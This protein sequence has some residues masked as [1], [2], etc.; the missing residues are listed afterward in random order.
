MIKIAV[1]GPESTGKS[2]I[3]A[4]LA[5][6]FNTVWVPEYARSYVAT[7]D[8][9][10]TLDDI[11]AIARGQ[12]ALEQEMQLQANDILFSDTD[13]L[14]LKIWSEHAFGHCPDWIQRQL[15]QQDY[16]L[17]LLMGVDLPWEPDPQREH[18]HLRQ[19]FY[20]WYKRELEA[21][22]APFVEI[23]GQEQ[24]RLELATKH[25]EALLTQR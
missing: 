20:H 13:M 14:V 16:N 3:A 2:T 6:R 11:E 22:G 1:T 8:Q 7:L 18:P 19:F 15:E 21:L 5:T 23:F 10:Y 9:P 12:L 25:V 17:C 4:Q 24:E